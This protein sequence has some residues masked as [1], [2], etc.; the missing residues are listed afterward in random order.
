[1][2]VYQYDICIYYKVYIFVATYLDQSL[3]GVLGPGL[4]EGPGSVADGEGE[5]GG[6]AFILGGVHED[7]AGQGGEAG[8]VLRK[9]GANEERH[10][11]THTHTTEGVGAEIQGRT[12]V[13]GPQLAFKTKTRQ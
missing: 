8:G 6:A 3:H 9:R 10:T 7:G 5:D 11:P 12:Q 1:M 4:G 2:F 13:I